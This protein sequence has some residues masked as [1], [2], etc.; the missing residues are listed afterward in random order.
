MLSC[1]FNSI[2]HFP[3]LKAFLQLKLGDSSNF[4]VHN[5]FKQVY[6]SSGKFRWNFYCDK[7]PKYNWKIPNLLNLEFRNLFFWHLRWEADGNFYP[8]GDA[9][10]HSWPL[11]GRLLYKCNP[12]PEVLPARIYKMDTWLT[13]F[14]I[15][16]IFV[17]GLSLD[18]TC[19]V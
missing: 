9:F 2:L 14:V 12:P 16:S 7:W 15:F 19:N 13:I 8:G 11:V 10:A 18:L 1:N 6:H 4:S 3:P 5:Q 17:W